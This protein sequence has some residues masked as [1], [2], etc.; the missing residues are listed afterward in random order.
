MKKIPVIGVPIVNGVNW[1]KRLIDSID[2][3]VENLFII[4]NNGKGEIDEELNKLTSLNHQFI[5]NFCV[6]NMPSNIGVAGS[7]NLIIKS[8]L[9]KPYWVISS[10]DVSFEPGLLEE[11]YQ[12]AQDDAVGIIHGSGGDFGDGTYDLFLIKDWVVQKIGLFDENCY[13][14]YCE[15]VDYIMR[16]TRWNWN[17]P[18]DGINR[19]N[20]DTPYYHGDRL[21]NEKNYYEGGFQTKKHNTDLSSKLDL[22]NL[23]NFEYMTQ[24][25]GSNWRMTNPGLNPMDIDRMPITYTSFDLEFVRRKYLGF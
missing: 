22:V 3:P 1:L 5:E 9:I 4:N 21:S 24:K 17:N 20:L 14:A 10:H 19:T 11:L 8:F 13:P 7:W 12:K 15:D 25:W 6:L 23:I 16:L 2:F 18:N